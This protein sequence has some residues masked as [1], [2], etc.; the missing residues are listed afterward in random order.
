MLLNRSQLDC[1]SYSATR[2]NV[3]RCS[4]RCDLRETLTGAACSGPSPGFCSSDIGRLLLDRISFG[5]ACWKGA[6]YA[7]LL[8]LVLLACISCR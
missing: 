1:H 3:Q 8:P 6:D 7:F 5:L 2:M 4:T